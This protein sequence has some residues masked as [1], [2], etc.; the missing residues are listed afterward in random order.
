MAQRL[1]GSDLVFNAQ[2]LVPVLEDYAFT[3]QQGTRHWVMEL[4]ISVHFQY[5]AIYTALEEGYRAGRA[6]F[7]GRDRAW[8][9]GDMLYIAEEWY[10]DCARNNE[11]MFGGAN[12]ARAITA[13][14]REVRATLDPHQQRSCDELCQR[15]TSVLR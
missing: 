2:C 5:E 13:S 9:A 1:A 14:L 3:N 12:Q 10:Q 15:I 11:R 7:I 4:C 6:P 8:L